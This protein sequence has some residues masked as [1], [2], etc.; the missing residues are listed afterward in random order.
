MIKIKEKEAILPDLKTIIL[1]VMNYLGVW[2]RN[3]KIIKHNRE[4]LNPFVQYLNIN[5]FFA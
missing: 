3:T 1:C 4:I 5:Y 2:E